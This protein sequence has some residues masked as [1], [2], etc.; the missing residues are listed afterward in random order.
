ME[1]KQVKINH[2][3]EQLAE[4]IDRVFSEG[5]GRKYDTKHCIE[6]AEAIYKDLNEEFKKNRKNQWIEGIYLL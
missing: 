5:F 4:I 2:T 1:S 3:V 6:I